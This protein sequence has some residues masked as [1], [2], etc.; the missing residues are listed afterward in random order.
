V[1]WPTIL[2]DAEFPP[3]LSTFEIGFGVA[4]FENYDLSAISFGASLHYHF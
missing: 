3:L 4:R 1:D 2:D